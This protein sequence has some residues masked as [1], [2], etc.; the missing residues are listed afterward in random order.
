M[1]SKQK[2][3][4]FFSL[5][6]SHLFFQIRIDFLFA[7]SSFGAET[8]SGYREEE[9][10]KKNFM[11][12]ESSSGSFVMKRRFFLNFILRNNIYIKFFL[13]K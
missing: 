3:P 9:K 10:G 2:K 6:R 13:N 8:I 5:F 11:Q 4:F 7:G 12:G 1:D